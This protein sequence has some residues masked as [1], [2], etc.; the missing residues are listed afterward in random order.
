MRIPSLNR[1]RLLH[2][3]PPIL[4]YNKYISN[5]HMFVIKILRRGAQNKCRSH[6]NG[7]PLHSDLLNDIII[8]KY[9]WKDL[10][11][12]W[13]PRKY[14]GIFYIEHRL[15]TYRVSSKKNLFS[16]FSTQIV[17]NFLIYIFIAFLFQMM[18][19]SSYF[20]GP[21]YLNTSVKTWRA[22]MT[23]LNDNDLGNE[24]PLR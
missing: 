1:G 24:K 3:T 13:N 17:I 12:R 19:F 10:T 15:C 9:K 11:C 21:Q 4:N 7:L 2:F 18:I 8:K 23:F 6:F 16:I 22:K 5:G 20:S 14:F